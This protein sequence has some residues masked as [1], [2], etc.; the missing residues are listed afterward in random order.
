MLT[1]ELQRV[2]NTQRRIEGQGPDVTVRAKFE[3]LTD[4]GVELVIDLSE[5][6]VP[7]FFGSEMEDLQHELHTTAAEL[8]RDIVPIRGVEF[9]YGGQ[10]VHHYFPEQ[11]QQETCCGRQKKRNHE[12]F[13][14]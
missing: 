4:G 1:A 8:L 3:T 10:H 11:R 7:K 2:V 9:R 5:S 12:G 6:Y 14:T 13:G